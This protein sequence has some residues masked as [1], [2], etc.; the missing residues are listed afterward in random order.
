MSTTDPA[1]VKKYTIKIIANFVSMSLGIV[2]Q[3]LVP[4]ALGPALFGQMSY[5]NSLFQNIFM[6]FDMG[7]INYFYTKLSSDSEDSNIS[8]FYLL[9]FFAISALILILTL[10]FL[11]SDLWVIFS[12]ENNQFF[13]Y[14]FFW[15][16]FYSLS[17]IFDKCADAIGVTI[18]AERIRIFNKVFFVGLLILLVTSSNFSLTKYFYYMFALYLSLLIQ[19]YF[20]FVSVNENIF[21]NVLKVISKFP[22]TFLDSFKYSKHLIAILLLGS[23]SIVFD[24]WLLQFVGGDEQQG[25]YSFAFVITSICLIFT[26]AFIPL[27]WREITLNLS[28]EN[29]RYLS[30]TIDSSFKFL[31]VLSSVICIFLFVFSDLITLLAGG[32]Q[33]EEAIAV[34]LI[35][36]LF[37]IHQTY[38]QLSSAMFLAL[39]QTKLYSRIAVSYIL[40]GLF[41]SPILLFN[42]EYFG[43]E[44]AAV[45]LALK[46]VIW[47]YFQVN[48][49]LYF[50]CTHAGSSFFRLLLHQHLIIF[51]MLFLCLGIRKFYG[52][53]L[54]IDN[55]IIVLVISFFSYSMIILIMSYLF[56]SS[57]GIKNSILDRLTILKP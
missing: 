24:R 36:S 56:K 31:F 3:I 39:S 9:Y 34:V 38:G 19:F 51:I 30:E 26:S 35:M 28:K 20:L 13:L 40:G 47:Q 32:E 17:L 10:L 27:I 50:N 43:I 33:Y 8:T 21:S 22:N 53:F 41:I 52:N 16:F 29:K 6:V 18:K 25:F 2:T 55:D 42:F 7:F 57:F 46:M 54:Q 45:A 4:R 11:A 49:Q 12:L 5:L 15:A 14:S 1:L 48:T 37:P 23:F 44:S